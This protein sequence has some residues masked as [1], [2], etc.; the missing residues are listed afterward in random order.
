M[1]RSERPPA[2]VWA[3]CL[4]AAIAVWL[5]AGPLRAE[6][7]RAERR[8]RIES[9]DAAGKEKLRKAQERFEALDKA[10]QKRLRDLSKDIQ[11]HPDRDPCGIL[12][13]CHFS[14]NPFPPSRPLRRR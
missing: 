3:V 13:S 4:T 7:T 5:R 8:A 9:M 11:T 14:D 1:R 6:E 10:E 2:A 12:N